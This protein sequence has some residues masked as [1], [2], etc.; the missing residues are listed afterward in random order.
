VH[1][2]K[3]KVKMLYFTQLLGVAL[4]V[5]PRKLSIHENVSDGLE[6]LDQDYPYEK[7][8]GT[9]RIL[10]IG[11][12]FVE[13]LQVGQEENFP[14]RL[15]ALLNETAS[16]PIEVINAGV[17]HYGT[18]NALL[19]LEN[20]GLRYQPDLVIYAFY[21]NDV[22]DNLESGF[23]SPEDGALIQ[24]PGEVSR[25][26]SL[27]ASLYDVSYLYRAGLGIAARLAQQTD[28]TLIDTEWGQVLPI[29]RAELLPREVSAWRLAGF[30]L[31]DIARATSDADARLLVVYLPEIFQSED[32]LWQ[33]V[34]NSDETLSRDAPNQ[35]LARIIPQGAEFLDLTEVFTQNA[36]TTSLYYAFD[37][38]FNAAGHELAA[39][40]LA[41]AIQVRP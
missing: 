20:E 23:F 35:Q 33:Q 12:S 36:Q 19:F 22:A 32:A 18:D 3:T 14:G 25:W 26:E 6:L 16:Q 27:R 28:D 39:E 38:H 4:G 21:P 15:E 30:L 29:Y 5:S 2:E 17:S 10:V 37:G 34:S 1:G 40:S 24:P 13:G 9:F 7:P 31:E 11:D 8:A 41:D